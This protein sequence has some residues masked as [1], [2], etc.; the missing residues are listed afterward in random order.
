[1]SGGRST[2]AFKVSYLGGK[3]DKGV[4]TSVVAPLSYPPGWA[5]REPSLIGNRLNGRGL[6][7]VK[8]VDFPCIHEAPLDYP[9]PVDGIVAG[10]VVPTP[11]SID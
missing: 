5:G 7:C 9:D 11:G 4:I 8:A 10:T 3:C 6:L 1:M 2:S